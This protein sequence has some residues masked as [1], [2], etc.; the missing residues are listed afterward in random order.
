VLAATYGL[1]D[2]LL[3]ARAQFYRTREL[4][5]A[6]IDGE[7]ERAGLRTSPPPEPRRLERMPIAMQL[8]RA[9]RRLAATGTTGPVPKSLA[10]ADARGAIAAL[11]GGEESSAEANSQ[12]KDR[13]TLCHELAP[14]GTRLATVRT[15]GGSLLSKSVF[16]HEPHVTADARNCD[17]CHTDIRESRAARDLNI[18]DVESCRE[19]HAEGKRA[20][21]A[22]GCEACHRYHVPSAGA[23]RGLP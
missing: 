3:A 16:T 10:D 17:S 13:C 6:R 18:P 21:K 4:D 22:I 5:R 9:M 12:R 11:L 19:C 7:L 2:D 15:P 23:L 20:A 8:D 1:P 14:G